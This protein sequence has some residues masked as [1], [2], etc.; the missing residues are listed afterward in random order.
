LKL[1]EKG[2]RLQFIEVLVE[3]VESKEPSKSLKEKKDNKE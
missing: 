3:K 1:E 2:Q